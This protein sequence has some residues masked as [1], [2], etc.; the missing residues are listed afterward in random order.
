MGSRK[1]HSVDLLIAKHMKC[2]G[3]LDDDVGQDLLRQIAAASAEDPKM[4][5]VMARH[6]LNEGHLQLIFYR[7]IDSIWPPQL[8]ECTGVVK[9]KYLV[10][11]IL[12]M[13]PG[14]IENIMSDLV[15]E[16]PLDLAEQMESP[17]QGMDA[18]ISYATNVVACKLAYRDQYFRIVS[19]DD[20]EA[21]DKGGLSAAHAKSGCFGLIIIA[22]SIGFLSHWSAKFIIWL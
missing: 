2:G 19:D 17:L 3:D 20:F 13:D 22:T 4:R 14:R 16:V 9:L 10:G 6:N 15:P 11:T 5:T 12:L 7:A 8:R 21:E 1:L 18:Q